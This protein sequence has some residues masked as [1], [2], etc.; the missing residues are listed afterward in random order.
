M[1]VGRLSRTVWALSV[2]LIFSRVSETVVYVTDTMFLSRVGVTE[3]AAIGL[4]TSIFEVSIFLTLGL[5][6]GIQILVARRAGEGRDEALGQ[7]FNHG[8]VLLLGVSIALMVALKVSAP[9]LTE[10]TVESEEVGAAVNDF[11]QIIA[12]GIVFNSA[13]LALTALFVALGDTRVLIGATIALALT[14]L[15]LDYV[16]IFGKFGFPAFGLEGAAMGAVGAE[17]VCFLYLIVHAVRHLDLK[18]YG[19]FRIGPWN[20]RL[21]GLLTRISWPVGAQALFESLRWF[22]FFLI[23]ER[24]GETALAISS[25]VYACYAVFLMPSEGFAETACTL[26]SK[27][28][29]RGQ[30]SRIAK[31]VRETTWP[32]YVVTGPILLIAL[33]FPSQVLSVFASDPSMIDGS[34][35]ALRVVA[36]A[37]LIIIPAHMWFAAVSGTGD[38]TAALGIEAI[39]TGA[40]LGCAYIAAVPLGMP[41]PKIWFS[42]PL[43]W[44]ACL[45][46]SYAWVRSGFWNRLEI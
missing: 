12:Y 8:L 35:G 24:V 26:V 39:I 3:L 1:R 10:W 20:T 37:M 45:L 4:A 32:T 5:V 30:A 41:L 42:L 9:L 25:V 7:T 44:A 31:L 13:S 40:M 36:L 14:N 18:R 11:L 33:F 16:F 23:I 2:P 19:L 46:L 34:V 17:V 6:D 43:A 38:T 29:G 21:F 15:G 27:V 22:L 28:I